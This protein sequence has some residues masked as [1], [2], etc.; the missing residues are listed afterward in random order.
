MRGRSLAL[1]SVFLTAPLGGQEPVSLPPSDSTA[2]LVDVVLRDGKGRPVGRGERL[3]RIAFT[4][5]P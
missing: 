3:I 1:A 4:V 2:V 5:A